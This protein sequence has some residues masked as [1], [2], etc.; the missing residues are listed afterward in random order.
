MCVSIAI[1]CFIN[2]FPLPHPAPPPPPSLPPHF[3]PPLPS[4]CPLS[5][6]VTVCELRG[7]QFE[8]NPLSINKPGI[9]VTCIYLFFEG[10]IYFLITLLIQVIMQCFRAS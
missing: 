6:P 1:T 7:V 8:D 4:L 10:I 5:G 2:P 3:S 9:G